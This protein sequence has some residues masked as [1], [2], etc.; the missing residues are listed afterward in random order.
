MG[1]VSTAMLMKGRRPLSADCPSQVVATRLPCETVAWL[2]GLGA[3][4]GL[5]AAVREVVES[6][7]RASEHDGVA[8][9]TEHPAVGQHELDGGADGRPAVEGSGGS[10][11]DE[12]VRGDGRGHATLAAHDTVGRD[13]SHIGRDH[14]LIVNVNVNEDKAVS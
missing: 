1:F 14:D 2:Q 5:S 11:S 9:V 10:V 8:E 4:G 6:V 3:R 13:G 12:G 7:R